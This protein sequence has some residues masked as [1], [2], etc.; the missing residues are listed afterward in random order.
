MRL[1]AVIA[2]LGFAAVP[3]GRGRLVGVRAALDG[4]A[5]IVEL[6]ADQP[7]SFT[8]LKL[9]GPPRIVVDLADTELGDVAREYEVAD[10]TVRRVA[11]AAAGTRT[12]RV[13]IELAGE[14]E[15]D[16]R[17]VGATLE[18]RVQRSSFPEGI[19]PGPVSG[20]LFFPFRGKT[21][22]LRALELLYESPD[23]SRKTTLA[24]F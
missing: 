23:G 14:S 21:K 12:A 17:A 11:V 8:T 18:V 5:S 4:Q 15:F 3:A 24:L 9:S 22:S 20:Y 16:V 7:L 10:G 6:E 19:I 2:L 1:A 13:V